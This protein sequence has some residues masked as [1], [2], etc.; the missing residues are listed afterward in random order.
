MGEV[1]LLIWPLIEIHGRRATIG[2][3]DEGA[4]GS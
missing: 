4:E 2:P 1:S 3:G